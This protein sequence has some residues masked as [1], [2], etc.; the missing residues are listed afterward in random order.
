MTTKLVL[1]LLLVPAVAHADYHGFTGAID[2]GGGATRTT[3]QAET[4]PSATEAGPMWGLTLG[5]FVRPDLALAFHGEFQFAPASLDDR[6]TKTGGSLLLAAEA[7]YWT[8]ADWSL[9]GGVAWGLF[10][11]QRKNPMTV[12][13]YLG[14]SDSGWAPLVG[15][16]YMAGH[17]AR[18][19]FEV[20]PVISSQ[21]LE[22]VVSNLSVGWQYLR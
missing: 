17:G 15:A 8:S 3:A 7:Q 18:I 20:A 19:S 4:N 9:T 1:A 21:G 16:S 6:L 10:A 14:V 12:N 5:A 22:G 11:Y 2:V 13:Q